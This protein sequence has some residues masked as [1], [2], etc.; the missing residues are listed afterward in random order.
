MTQLVF[1]VLMLLVL[2]W[3]VASDRLA[4]SNI[5]GPLVFTVAGYL[6]AN[7]TWSPLSVDVDAPTVHV[8]AEGR[9]LPVWH[10]MVRAQGGDPDAP[11]AVASETETVVAERSG[12][13]TRLDARAVGVCA[14]RLGAGRSRKEDPVSES[15]GV[16]CRKKPGD[17]VRAGDVLLELHIDDPARVE[18]AREALAGAYDIGDTAPPAPPVVFARIRG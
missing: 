8:L 1:A 18:Y 5:T 16:V 3:A 4:R 6:L 9:A 15:A 7:G 14:W 2:G 10:E 11:L 17:A 12:L 13:L